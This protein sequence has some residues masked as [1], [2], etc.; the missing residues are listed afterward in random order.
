MNARIWIGT[1]LAMLA[2]AP[3]SAFAE[4]MRCGKWVVSEESTPAEIM[5]KCGTPLER[6]QNT[7]DVFGK[8]PEGYR[9]KTGTTTTERWYYQPGP[10]AFRM[11]VT[12]VDGDVKHIERAP[13]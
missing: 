4:S 7:E 8:N 11:L 12:I 5:E 2:S 9:F 13:D 1:A 3:W 6:E 10:G